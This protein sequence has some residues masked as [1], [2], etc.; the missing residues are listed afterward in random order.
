ML[1]WQRATAADVWTRLNTSVRTWRY[2][3]SLTVTNWPVEVTLMRL[4]QL[5]YRLR[6]RV[7]SSAAA[8]WSYPGHWD[9][10][11]RLDTG[12]DGCHPAGSL[13][14]HAAAWASSLRRTIVHHANHLRVERRWNQDRISRQIRIY[15]Q[16]ASQQTYVLFTLCD[17]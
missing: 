3:I 9:Q 4:L 12:Q 14:Q 11:P 1:S 13:L 7:Q 15:R 8:A 6:R 2:G 10:G 17:V 16:E 5:H